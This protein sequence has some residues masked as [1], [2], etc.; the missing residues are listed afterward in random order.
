LLPVLALAGAAVAWPAVSMPHA[1][2]IRAS[3]AARAALAHAPAR[4]ELTFSERIE[5]AYSRVSVWDAA[6]HQVEHQPVTVGSDDPRVLSVALP[7]LGPGTYT[8]RYRVLS[9][10]GHVVEGAF[11]FALR[12]R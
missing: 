8:V 10:D 2:L 5:P 6:G 9:I 4:V 7:P 12:D 1:A 11:P 3:P